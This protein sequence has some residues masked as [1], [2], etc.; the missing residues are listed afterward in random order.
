MP[1]SMQ[2]LMTSI[3]HKHAWL[4]A[5]DGALAGLEREIADLEQMAAQLRADL[6]APLPVVP[7]P[8]DLIRTPA[9]SIPDGF[10]ERP[11]PPTLADLPLADEAPEG[12]ACALVEAAHAAD[13][14]PAPTGL[15]H[16]PASLREAWLPS[17]VLSGARV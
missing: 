12:P 9:L 15:H 14:E 3:N 16:K 10:D 4:M 8:D 6:A 13:G 2:K 5:V 1:K 17:P 7:L 11:A